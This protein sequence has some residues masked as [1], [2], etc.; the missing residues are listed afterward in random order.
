MRR[1]KA[2]ALIVLAVGCAAAIG[3]TV[4]RLDG[5]IS[6]LANYR[7]DS[8]DPIW[9]N[10]SSPATDS[11]AL[12]AAGRILPSDATYYLYVPTGP[13]G[14]F[15]DVQG[16]AL[17]FFSPALPVQTPADASWVLSYRPP[18]YPPRPL[19]PADVVARQVYRL[20]GGVAL[21]RVSK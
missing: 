5:P 4:P 17:L 18:G 14:L 8:A 11:A 7:A 13:P 20:G 12:R 2:R 16:A 1:A 3:A 21:V 9:D 15:H 19:L 10:R 6:R